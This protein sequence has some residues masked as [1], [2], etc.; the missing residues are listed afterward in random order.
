MKIIIFSF[1]A[2]IISISAIV[3]YKSTEKKIIQEVSYRSIP[4]FNEI[5]ILK[6]LLKKEHQKVEKLKQEVNSSKKYTSNKK[7]SVFLPIK[8]T[9][10]KIYKPRKTN[11]KPT[12]FVKKIVKK[13]RKPLLA[14]IIDDIAN[15]TH[16]KIMKSVPFKLTPSIFPP[17]STHPNTPSYTKLFDFYML[18]LPTQ[19]SNPNFRAEEKTL[20][21]TSSNSF[22]DTRLK[23]IRKWFPD[24]VF[25]NNHTGSKFT[26][27]YPAMKKLFNA[28]N[29]YNFIFVDSKTTAKSMGPRL[30]K[31]FNKNLLS[32]DIFLDHKVNK[33]YSIGQIKKAI[34]V[35][36]LNGYAIAIGHPHLTTIAALKESKELL[37]EVKLVYLDELYKYVYGRIKP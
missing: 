20:N 25:I 24:L 18:H 17:S 11:Y 9:T 37:K 27:S 19:S 31:E 6:E 28:I 14:I 12:K 15:K 30:A 35:A 33:N 5:N 13:S 2:I 21:T 16:I 22:I 29:K 7:A 36:K 3:Y 1:F 23:N 34:K 10:K 4:T 8:Y 26:S 32:R